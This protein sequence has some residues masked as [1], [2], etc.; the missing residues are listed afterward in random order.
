MKITRKHHYA[1]DDARARVTKLLDEFQKTRPGF[2][3]KLTWNGNSAQASGSQFTGSFDLT[4]DTLDVNIQLSWAAKL[5][6]GVVR[7]Q[8]EAALEPDF[9]A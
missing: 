6:E 2:I 5:F 8:L 7:T 4:P 3:Q 9:P 1:M